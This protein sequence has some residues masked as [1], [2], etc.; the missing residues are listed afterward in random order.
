MRAAA[1][2]PGR[3]DR[4]LVENWSALRPVATGLGIDPGDTNQL[5]VLARAYQRILDGVD[6]AHVNW[7]ETLALLKRDQ[8]GGCECALTASAV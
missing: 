5:R 1:K 3:L 2:A 8:T 6:D 4:V 7:C